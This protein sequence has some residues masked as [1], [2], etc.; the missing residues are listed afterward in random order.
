M[1]EIFEIFKFNFFESKR[2]NYPTKC[3]TFI[4]FFESDIRILFSLEAMRKYKRPQLN[5][6]TVEN[7]VKLMTR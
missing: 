6:L 5:D 1:D 2:T 3:I 7:D 4:L